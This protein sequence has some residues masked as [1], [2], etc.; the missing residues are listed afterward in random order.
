MCT[1]LCRCKE[2]RRTRHSGLGQ[3]PRDNSSRKH[4]F[5]HSDRA[6]D[7]LFSSAK[8]F[9]MEVTLSSRF[10]LRNVLRFESSSNFAALLIS[11]QSRNFERELVSAIHPAVAQTV[12]REV[13]KAINN[14]RVIVADDWSYSY[15]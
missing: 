1:G 7:A 15:F 14:S 5:S 11:Q 13:T 8:N 9:V 4:L 3:I 6:S 10:L 2:T 12:D